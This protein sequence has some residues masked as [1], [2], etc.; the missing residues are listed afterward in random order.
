M[1]FSFV[2][3][4]DDTEIVVR[5]PEEERAALDE[6][7]QMSERFKTKFEVVGDQVVISPS[8]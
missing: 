3:Q 4:N 6:I 2:R 8:A 1:G 5:P 7:R